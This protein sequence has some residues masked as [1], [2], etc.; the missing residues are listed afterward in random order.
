MSTFEGTI[1][2]VDDHVALA[3][4]LAEILGDE[5][6]RTSW[7]DSAEAA[8]DR[9]AKGG[10]SALITDYRLPGR[11]GAELIGE[12]R[13]RGVDIPIIVM[14]AHTDDGIIELSE[15]AG[16]LEV[17]PKPVDLGRLMAIVNHL[18]RGESTIL[19][20]DDNRAMADNLAEAL[21]GQGHDVIVEGSL[22]TALAQRGRPVVAI[23]DYRLPD[24][25]GVEVAERLI[26]RD[27]RIRVLFVSGHGAELGAELGGHLAGAPRI[28]KP[29][30]LSV[31]LAL[32][33]KAISNGQTPRPDR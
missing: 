10:I 25:T 22:T 3:E 14:S 20:V 2:V 24:G 18:G 9:V 23:L 11:S 15:A 33:A 13:R 7:A 1:L 4:N 26:A 6:F 12:L 5:G 27:P 8:L 30:D 28:E 21:R 31:L 32:V 17:L 19:V 16:A 29:V